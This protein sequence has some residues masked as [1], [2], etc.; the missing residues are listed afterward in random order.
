MPAKAVVDRAISTGMEYI[1]GQQLPN[2]G[3]AS[4]S[5]PS[6][7][8]FKPEITLRTTFTPSLILAAL[9]AARIP[10]SQ[11]VCGRTVD[12][13]RGQAGAHWSFNYWAKRTRERRMQPYPDDL[14]DTF[15]A[16]AAL[17]SYDPAVVGAGVLAKATKLLLATEV[18]VGGPYRTWLVSSDSEPVWRDIDVAVNA[19]V[20][21]FLTL[22]G[23][24]LPKLTGFLDD[25]IKR[26]QLGSPYY[27]SARVPAYY[28]A[29]GYNGKQGGELIK[30]I[31]GLLDSSGTALDLA[32]CVSSLL[33]LDPAACPDDAVASLLRMQA[34]D[35]AWP[36]AAF[37]LDP[38]IKGQPYYNGAPALTT[39]CALEALGLYRQTGQAPSAKPAGSSQPKP[40]DSIL[41]MGKSQL[42]G[43]AP[44]LRASMLWSL[45]A[46]ASSS[47]GPEI[48]Y[49]AARFRQSLAKPARRRPPANL[50]QT[51]GLANLYGWLA[52]TIYDDFLDEEGK[53]ELLSVANVAMRRSLEN[54]FSALPS[55]RNF[56]RLVRQIF[57]T[58][59]SANAWELAHCR[60]ERRGDC[61]VVGR[62]PAY[63]DL[64]KLAERSLGHA[65]SPMAVLAAAGTSPTSAPAQQTLQAFRHYLIARQLN[66][67]AHDW[68]EDL[69]NGH[70]TPV[71]ARL[72]K[73]LKVKPG[74]YSV[75]ILLKGARPQFWN[76]TLPEIC[77]QMRRH[78]RLSRQA[79][80]RSA[81]FQTENVV[82]DLLNSLETSVADTLHQ[83]GQ[84]KT[85]LKQY[86]NH[87]K[88][89]A[90]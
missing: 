40:R 47:N 26:R 63:G 77:R 29:R 16:L 68:P 22:I 34:A 49:L 2:G 36:A 9:A 5:S 66:D 78:I 73:D 32:L 90:K 18:T 88:K 8:P 86:N 56:H 25:A 7:L 19:N 87:Y 59:D 17:Y 55:N 30:F 61:L 85:F 52:Y 62:L 57:D 20:A 10:G 74:E 6:L 81:V 71:V 69:R 28:I 4:F 53:P 64:S 75:D 12:F 60:F 11:K 15:C 27:P 50:I 65:L 1:A 76:F 82:S 84:A 42:E 21:Y 89:G 45:E 13:L 51:L 43:L 79:L 44:D 67:D 39:A 33:R 31:S 48:M 37:C 3:F 46:M 83:Q 23:S 72:L 38:A 54:Y 35:G 24:P 70:I 58:I 41:E 14:D 80:K